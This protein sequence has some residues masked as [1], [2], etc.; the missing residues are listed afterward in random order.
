MVLKSTKCE[1]VVN[2]VNH[3]QGYGWIRCQPGEKQ[4]GC[5][6]LITDLQDLKMGDRVHFEMQRDPETERPQAKQITVKPRPFRSMAELMGDAMPYRAER[7]PRGAIE[8]LKQKRDLR[9]IGVALY[10]PPTQQPADYPARQYSP[11]RAA[12]AGADAVAA[13]PAVAALVPNMGS[14]CVQPK[15][16][17]G[18]VTVDSQGT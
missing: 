2:Y 13:D 4:F 18:Q 14:P 17:P 10:Q 12:D 8:V 15:A 7:D 11:A 9:S 3:A 6:V 1:G 16:N 5:D